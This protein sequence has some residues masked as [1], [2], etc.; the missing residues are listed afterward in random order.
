[1]T[2]AVLSGI[3]YGGVLAY[4]L[5]YEPPVAGVDAVVG[6][7]GAAF[8]LI[9]LVR[10]TVELLPWAL[11]VLGVAYAIAIATHG[12]G[13]DE[14]AP[15]VGAGLLLCG[16]LAAWSVDE[17][18]RVRAERAVLVGRTTAVAALALTGALAGGLVLS[19]AAAPLGH[20][21]AWTFLGT[22]AAV[23]IMA[24]ATRLGR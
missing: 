24:I 9:V 11:G 14:G 18:V 4:T 10:S 5:V 3:A 15:F 22:A 21:L 17:R 1:M 13:V 23:A 19:L 16:E 2:L 6:G 12:S 8:L 7:I 20:G